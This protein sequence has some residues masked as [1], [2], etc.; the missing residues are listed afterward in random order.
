[1]ARIEGGSGDKGREREWLARA[2][3]APRDRAWIADGYIS[4]RWLPVSPVTGLVDAFEW[5]APADAIGRP[6]ETLQIDEWTEPPRDASAMLRDNQEVS[7]STERD[8]ASPSGQKAEDIAPPK[9]ETVIEGTATEVAVT[10]PEK[11][12]DDKRDAEGA[13]TS[14]GESTAADL[15][16]NKKNE[17]VGSA[18]SRSSARDGSALSRDGGGAATQAAADG[19]RASAILM[20]PRAPDDPGVAPESEDESKAS[21]ERFRSAHI[22]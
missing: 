21:L 9:D 10:E 8:Q 4:D 5:R 19:D 1:M 12:P 14:T 7:A 11:G 18:G 13:R 6:D 16:A 22:R 3:R 2:L 15:D 20:P 17:S